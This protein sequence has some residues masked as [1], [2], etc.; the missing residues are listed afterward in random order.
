MSADEPTAKGYITREATVWCGK[1]WTWDQM[2][3]PRLRPAIAE[4]VRIGWTRTR[5]DGWR[6]PTCS[7]EAKKNM[8]TAKKTANANNDNE[9]K[10]STR[11]TG[12]SK[13][14]KTL[15]RKVN[16]AAIRKE[17]RNHVKESAES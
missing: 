16:R 7:K 2:S 6:C 15:A 14:A 3:A 5:K 11:T 9:G 1:C 4:W 10:A 12:G 8:K 17:K 13:A